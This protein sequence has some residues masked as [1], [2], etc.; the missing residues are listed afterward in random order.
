M[1]RL[2]VLAATGLMLLGS[3]QQSGATGI[4]RLYARYP[5]WEDSPIFNL[6]IK[7]LH[8]SVTIRNQLAVTHVDQEFANDSWN[9]LEG[10]YVFQLPEGANVNE[11]A[12]WIN[13]QRVPYVIK[14]REEAIV[15]YN[16]IV[17]RLTDPAILEQLGRNLFRLRIFPIDAYSSR[18]IEIQYLQ[19]LPLSEGGLDYAFPLDMSDYTTSPIERLSISIDLLSDYA[20]ASLTTSVDQ[21]PTATIVTKHSDYHYSVV[22]GV[23]NVAFAQDFA[24][25]FAINRGNRHMQ[26]LTYTAPDSLQ[27]DPYFILWATLPDTLSDSA[28]IEGKELVFVADVSSSMEGVRMQ[29]LKEALHAFVDSLAAED[30]FTIITFGTNV[31]QFRDS[32]V[33]ATPE[34]KSEAGHF[35]DRLVAIGLTNI[36][37]ALREAVGK[38]YTSNVKS[39]IV[40]LTDGEPTWGETN[41][42]SILT[43]IARENANDVRIFPVG[44]GD[45]LEVTLLEQIAQQTGGT[46]TLVTSSDSIALAIRTLVKHL[47]SPALV[48]ATLDYGQLF[49]LDIYPPSLPTAF[50]GEQIIQTGRFQHAAT[51]SVKLTGTVQNTPFEL[52]DSLAFTDTSRAMVAVERY[53]GAQKIL[54]LL[55]LIKQLGE[56]KELVDQVVALSIRYAVLTP[57]TAFLVVEPGQGSIIGVGGE[58]TAV[59]EFALLQ[60]FPNPFNPSTTI[61]YAVPGTRSGE[62][63][64]VTLVVYDILGQEIKTLVAET[65]SPG[66]HTV[67]WDG[68]DNSGRRVS[69]GV[70]IYRL[71]AGSYSSSMRMVLMK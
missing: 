26:V 57:Y 19:P 22:Y 66:L 67:A 41:T 61:R 3:V 64:P 16:E 20:I 39:A 52:Q 5:N 46:L 38:Q 63:V 27:E 9:R 50:G 36:E 25:R 53:W 10:F 21:F 60:N 8:T 43:H 37:A 13:G 7:T 44:I 65:Q 68:T 14:R 49:P 69:S 11:M 32:L 30:K 2:L 47:F 15:I 70:Y 6:R 62:T 45:D 17:R 42:D 71:T 59:T 28:P 1:K 55:N 4:G 31:V 48:N 18:R 51:G 34:M 35:I 24:L 56:V 58:E 12:L 29:Q 33:L 23:E 40:F 54:Y